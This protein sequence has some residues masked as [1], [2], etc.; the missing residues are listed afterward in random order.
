MSLDSM[1]PAIVKS[2]DRDR[3]ECRIEIPGLTDGCQIFPLAEI[4]YPIGYESENSEIRIPIGARVRVFFDGGDPRFPVICAFRPRRTDNDTLWRREFHENFARTA[5]DG[6]IN[7]S[8]SEDINVDAGN[9]INTDV[10]HD[11][12]TDVTHDE[13]HTVGHEFI[14]DATSKAT[15]HVGSSTFV[16]E[17]S[18]ITIT[19][20]HLIVNSAQSN[21]SGAVTVAGLLT[22]SAGLA[23]SGGG[24][25]SATITG[26]VSVTGTIT[27]TT[28]VVGGGKSL[29]T[30]T[31]SGVAAGSGTS[32]PPT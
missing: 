16:V 1:Y 10:G 12:I 20:P 11:M 3:R 6:D 30:H 24:G 2:W 5:D 13:H 21:F 14:L 17:S 8:A 7:D 32:G 26:N 27:G 9:D 23:G 4:D 22:Y 29:K 25:T 19:T 18:Q 31:H 15:I 28:D